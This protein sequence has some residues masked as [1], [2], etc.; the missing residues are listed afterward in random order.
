MITV[1]ITKAYGSGAAQTETLYFA[2]SSRRDSSGNTGFVTESTDT[3]ASTAFHTRIVDPGNIGRHA[4]ADGKTAGYTRLEVGAIKLDN[5]DGYFDDW[6]DWHVNLDGRAVV[7][8]EGTAGTAYP[9]AW[10]T[11]L[12]GTIENFEITRSTLTI[13]VRDK[14]FLLNKPVSQNVYLGDNVAPDGLEGTPDDLGNKRKPVG[15]GT[16]QNIGPPL[17]NASKLI[18]QVKD[19]PVDDISAVYDRGASLTKGSDYTSEAQMLSVA[20]TAGQYRCWLTGGYFRLGASPDGQITAYG[21]YASGQPPVAAFIGTPLSGNSPLTV[22]FT[23]QSTGNPTTWL[24]TFG[25]GQTTSGSPNVQHPIHVYASPGTYTVTLTVTNAY[26]SSTA[27]ETAYVTA[28]AIELFLAVAHSVT[29]FVTIYEQQLSPSA[30]TK[31]A[32]PSSLPADVGRGIAFSTDGSLLAV[33]HEST[34]FIAIY[35][36]DVR[37]K[38]ANPANLPAGTGVAVAFSPD[39]SMLAMAHSSAPALTI[40]NTDDWTKQE[41]PAVLPTTNGH[42]VAFTPDGLTLAVGHNLT[43]FITLYQRQGSPLVW[44]K[45]AAPSTLPPATVLGIAFNPAGT[46]MALANSGGTPYISIYSSTGSPTGWHKIADP[47]TLP[48]GDAYGCAFSP[49]GELLAVA[50]DVSPYLIVY[51]TDDWTTVTISDLPVSNAASVHFSADGA[52]LA[53]GHSNTPFLTIYDV[54]TWAKTS[55][56]ATLPTGRGHGVKFGSL[57]AQQTLVYDSFTGGAGSPSTPMTAHTPDT[58][59]SWFHADVSWDTDTGAPQ[60][61]GAGAIGPAVKWSAIGN[62]TLIP[63]RHSVTVSAHFDDVTAGPLGDAGFNYSDIFYSINRWADAAGNNNEYVE[64]YMLYEETGGG[65]GWQIKLAANYQPTTGGVAGTAQ[66]FTGSVLASGA[67]PASVTPW[68]GTIKVRWLSTSV[69]LYLNG[70]LLTTFTRD[71]TVPYYNSVGSS[72]LWFV[73]RWPGDIGFAEILD[74]RIEG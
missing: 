21:E 14:S 38:L 64:V 60:L 22:T 8:R 49:D 56:P 51:R 15:Y 46:L 37:V 43:P 53:V 35:E 40:W 65:T 57:Y 28:T 42:S 67:L 6:L 59:G 41:N 69:Q 63:D 36:T 2:D 44:T 20:P 18:Y 7:I 29:P 58:G 31:L 70:A 52:Y 72:H 61:D 47:S 11:L 34:P 33:A 10:T 55:S 27:T 39:D 48:T 9:S 25:D 12:T 74:I 4:Y 50:I 23:D 71:S 24:W 5:S 3:P 1:E 66:G 54:A 45:I 16:W 32:N 30:L 17:V 26:G 13:N 62:T 19:G 68:D 73:E